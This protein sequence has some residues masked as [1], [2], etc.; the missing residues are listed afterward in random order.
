MLAQNEGNTKQ[1]AVCFSYK[2]SCVSPTYPSHMP[3]TSKARHY[4]VEPAERN[5]GYDFVHRYSLYLIF[6]WL[7]TGYLVNDSMAASTT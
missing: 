6:H 3:E 5:E 1:E 2:L 7:A 4:P